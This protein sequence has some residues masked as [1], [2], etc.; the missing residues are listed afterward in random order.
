[1]GDLFTPLKI[2]RCVL[3]DIKPLSDNLLLAQDALPQEQNVGLDEM[4]KGPF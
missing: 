2:R 4:A 1:M 3:E